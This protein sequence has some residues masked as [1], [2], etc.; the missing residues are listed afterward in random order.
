M[1]LTAIVFGLI[2][3][4]SWG[5]ADFLAAKASKRFGGLATGVVVT[6]ISALVFDLVY[7][8]FFQSHT[9]WNTAGVV[10]A[11]ASGVAFTV[12]NLTFYK[13]LEYGPV[14]I[15][16]PLGSLYPLITTMALV[17]FFGTVLSPRQYVGIAVVM[18]GILAA[19]GLF[20]RVKT[21]RRMSPGPLLGLLGALFWGLAWTFIAQAVTHIGW[22]FTA[23]IELTFSSLLLLPLLPLLNRS[24]SGIAKQLL[25][26]MKNAVMLSAGILMMCG[27]LALSIGLERVGDLAATAVVISACY[28]IITVFLALKN[29]KEKVQAIPLAGAFVGIAGVVI[30]S[31][32]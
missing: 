7:L 29:L 11:L 25:P 23:M 28:P 8:L 1:A 17:S 21:G 32:G 6:I 27:F 10:F 22:Q 14:S 24:E 3:A 19:S 15:V 9:V 2:A 5:L 4:V 16:S 18:L 31:L 30:L 12:A 20:E 26:S 13:G